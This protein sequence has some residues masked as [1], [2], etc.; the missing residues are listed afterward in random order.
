MENQKQKFGLF[1][2]ISMIVGVV[3]GSGIFFKTDDI[4]LASNGNIILG[5]LLLV[6][7][8]VGIVFGGLC[9]SQYA[10]ENSEAGGLITYAEM[11]WGK[12]LGYLS[13]WFQT[14]FY[15]PA[16]IA[17]LAWIAA[18]YTGHLFGISNPHDIRLWVITLLIIIIS[19]TLNI[20]NTKAAGKFQNITLVIKI[21]ALLILSILGLVFGDIANIT[22]GPKLSQSL[23]TGMFA[24]LI[25][26]AFSYDGWFVAPAIAHEIKDPKRNLSKALVLSPL[27]ILGIY[28]MYFFG[29]SIYLGSDTVISLGDQSVGIIAESLFGSFGGKA[30]Y[31]A[32]IISILGT[33]NGLVLGYIRLPYS[34]AL[35][36]RFP[37]SDIFR[38]LNTK[39]DIPVQSAFLTAVLVLI[40]VGLHSLSVFDVSIGSLKF[41]GLQ[42]DSLPIV[43]T[44]FFFSTLYIRLILTELRA[45]TYGFRYGILYPTLAILGACL[46]IYGG[47][48]QPGALIY[49]IISFIGIALGYFLMKK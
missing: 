38:K 2:T 36:E 10:K 3:I 47:L 27:I 31:I 9:V 45:H 15:Y 48:T 4:L 1:T 32:V 37:L 7:G 12:T 8:A 39:L 46:V 16:I 19:F 11:A 14:I 18:I 42:I 41:I 29:I 25:A 40:W 24:G 34:L 28:L 49:F 33:I 43:L 22:H 21:A 17:V 35:R 6:L 30:V 20:L 23:S 44:Y 5:A 13:G 26:C